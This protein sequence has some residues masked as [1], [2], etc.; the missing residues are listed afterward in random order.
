[1]VEL[2]H[3]DY[4]RVFLLEGGA[5]P[6]IDPQYMSL[7]KAGAISWDQGDTTIVYIP[8]PDHYQKFVAAGKIAGEPYNPEIALAARYTLDKSKLLALL[9]HGCDHVLQVHFG[10]C[11]NPRDANA[12]W[13]KIVVLMDASVGSYGTGDLGALEPSQRAQVDEDSS[14]RGSDLYEIMRLVFAQ[15][16]AA[17]TTEEVLDIAFGSAD[18]CLAICVSV[19]GKILLAIMT[20]VAYAKARYIFSDDGGLT[21]TDGSVTSAAADDILPAIINIGSYVVVLNRTADAFEYCEQVDLIAGAPTWAQVSTGFVGVGSPNAIFSAGPA[22]SW[23]VG[24]GGYVYKLTNVA[25]GVVVQDAGSATAQNLAAVHGMDENSI[26]AV[27]A[28]NAVIYTTNGGLNWVAVTGPAAGVN[29]TACWML[30][31]LTWLVGDAAGKLWY[32]TDGGTTWAEKVFTG[33]GAGSIADLKFMDDGLVGYMA[34][35]TAAPA[36]RIL[37]TIDGGSSWYVLPEG[38]GSI[39]ANLAINALAVGNDANVVFGGGLVTGS[40]GIIVA[41]Q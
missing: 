32:T 40:A 24:D 6:S 29:L 13:D 18:Q 16:A 5:G 37:R 1:M 23:I 38:T 2:I 14:F 11:R 27:G 12:G 20:P 26:M 10:T 35:T 15:K 33:C 31:A 39:P 4:S 41:A 17:E 34:H 8:D 25:D 9:R 21:W 36:G 7:W 3:S 28:D 30:N 19:E 22:T